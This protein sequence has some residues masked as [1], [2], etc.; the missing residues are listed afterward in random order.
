MIWVI[1]GYMWLFIHRP[2]EIWSWLGPLHI[3]RIY[4]I[5]TLAMWFAVAEKQLTENKHNLSIVLFAFAMTVSTAM[6]SYTNIF[7]S[8]AYQDWLKY[9]AF[10]VLVMTSV[11][12]EKDL[13]ILLTA[14]LICTFLYIV[15]SYREYL[16]GRYDFKMGTKRM[17]GIDLTMNNPNAFGASIVVWLPFILPLL[18]LMK[19]KW[20]YL[21]II[22]YVLLSIRCVQLTGSRS[23]FLML[24]VALAGAGVLSKHRM[25]LIP[26]MLLVGVVI[27]FSLS[28]NLQDRYRSIFDPTVNESANESARGRIEGFLDGIQNWKNS[29]IWGVGPDCHGIA[30]GHGFLSHFLYGQIPGELGTLGVLAFLSLLMCFVIN[31][32]QIRQHYLELKRKGY[33]KDGVYCYRVSQTIMASVVLL[34]FFGLSGHNGYRSNWIWY[35]AFQAVTL[36]ILNRKVTAI[37]KEILFNRLALLRPATSFPKKV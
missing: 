22:C 35:P 26:V 8:T 6:S 5:C 4:M 10:Y 31:H 9:L 21:F 30:V 33:E 25:K 16:A 3:E 13:K 20:H 7:D 37:N 19:K 15:H 28:E 32:L 27:W 18:L 1:V 14:F 11:K 24:G 29:P 17:I 34:L 12:T 36:D 2:F 23:A